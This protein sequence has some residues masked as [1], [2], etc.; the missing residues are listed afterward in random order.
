[1]VNFIVVTISRCDYFTARNMLI[2]EQVI[3]RIHPNE[4]RFNRPTCVQDARRY[5]VRVLHF[6]HVRSWVKS[7]ESGFAKDRTDKFYFPKHTLDRAS[8]ERLAT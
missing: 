7:Y 2:A 1:M 4:I 3:Q 6:R 8:T 5:V